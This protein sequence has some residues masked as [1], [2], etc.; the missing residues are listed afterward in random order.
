MFWRGGSVRTVHN[1]LESFPR[2]L[3]ARLLY[4]LTSTFFCM[5]ETLNAITNNRS[6]YQ[7][8][9][10]EW[11]LTTGK[12]SLRVI[13]N[14]ENPRK[15]LLFADVMIFVWMWK[16]LRDFLTPLLALLSIILRF[17]FF[18][19]R[20]TIIEGIFSLSKYLSPLHSLPCECHYVV[21]FMRY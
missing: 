11:K 18:Q 4:L 15:K 13:N 16:V 17:H 6:H 10:D 21:F 2:A 20:E 9:T 3:I 19:S 8:H 7:L 5:I 1:A 14:F 12:M